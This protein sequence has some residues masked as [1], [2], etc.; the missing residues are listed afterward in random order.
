[1]TIK[2]F[3]GFRSMETHHCVTGSML[4]IYDF[5]NHPISEEMLLGIGSGVGFIYWHIKGMEPIFGGRGNVGRPGEEG[6]EVTAGRRTGVRVEKHHT[7]SIKKAE[8]TMLELLEAGRPVMINVD[9]GFLPYFEHLPED[10]HFGGHAIVVGGYDP[11]TKEVLVAD[12][13]RPLHPVL[14]EDLVK[15]RGSKYKPFPP[16]NMWFTFDFNEKR[17]PTTDEIS[18]AI[19]DVCTAMLEGPISNIGVRGIRKA[20][21]KVLEWPKIMNDEE[22]R[23]SCFNTYIFIDAEG[24]TGGGIFR[25]MYGRFLEEVAGIL[26]VKELAQIGEGMRVIGDKWQDVAGIFK[27]GS[28]AK[29]PAVLLRETTEPLQEIA[30]LEGESWRRLREMLVQ[31]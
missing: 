12:R 7:G 19:G 6:L 24:G 11:E 1:M 16:M 23:W 28:E 26:D 21:K 13:D 10:F 9:M 2:P 3:N 27:R 8:K 17:Q 22:L 15:A 5:Y 25:Y 18:E 4:H 29:D 31:T 30:E 20:A 14:W